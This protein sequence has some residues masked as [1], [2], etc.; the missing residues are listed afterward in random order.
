MSDRGYLKQ[1]LYEA[2]ND[3]FTEKGLEMGLTYAAT[4]ILHVRKVP[5]EFRA[6]FEQIKADLLATPLG[7]DTG[8]VPRDVTPWEANT[9]ARRILSLYTRVMGGL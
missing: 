3:L 1:K 5:E 4:Y 9:L 8:Y 2:V 6:E 7:T